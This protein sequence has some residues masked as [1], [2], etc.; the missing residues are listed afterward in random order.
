MIFKQ[1]IEMHS[2]EEIKVSLESLYPHGH[3]DI[4]AYE[5]VFAILPQ[6]EVEVSDLR[7]TIEEIDDPCT[8]SSMVSVVGEND[9]H[10]YAIEFTKWEQWLGMEVNQ[11]TLREYS[12]LEII[13]HSLWE[14]TFVGYSQEAITA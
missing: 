6:L 8:S 3:A 12:E 9:E 2:W 7:L 1:P 14:M 13:A 10:S 11:S 4:S 5:K